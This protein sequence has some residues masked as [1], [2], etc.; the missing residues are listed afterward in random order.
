MA[1]TSS[2]LAATGK[3]FYHCF[4]VSGSSDC[5]SCSHSLQAIWIRNAVFHALRDSS[6]VSPVAVSPNLVYE[7]P[8][9]ASLAQHVSSIAQA[10]PDAVDEGELQRRPGEV[11]TFLAR[12][13]TTF[14]KHM[15]S[16][17]DV[18][19]VTGTT[20]ALG[21]AVLAKL[22]S[23]DCV[24]KIFAY[25]RPSREGIGITQRQKE[26][27][28]TRGYDEEIAVSPKVILVEGELTA[29]GLGINLPLE[30]EVR[31]SIFPFN[32]QPLIFEIPS[33]SVERSLILFIL[34]MTVINFHSLLTEMTLVY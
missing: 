13:I 12:Y 21:S 3:L 17:K 6:S 19:L 25:N 10:L 33:R 1:M 15:P 20:G 14:P 31:L 11:E 27:L 8:T 22:V 18:V 29:S 28:R 16:L 23:S 4:P 26:A 7:H 32:L 34:V 5:I 30:E 24:G 2:T 9:I